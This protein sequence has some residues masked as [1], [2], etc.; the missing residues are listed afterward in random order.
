[1]DI[2]CQSPWNRKSCPHLLQSSLR[3]TLLIEQILQL[4]AYHPIHGIIVASP[5]AQFDGSRFNDPEYVRSYRSLML[6]D[7][8]HERHG[9]GARLEGEPRNIEIGFRGNADIQI[10]FD[11]ENI[12]VEQQLAVNVDGTATQLTTLSSRIDTVV[13]YVFGLEVSVNRASYGQLT[14]G[15]PLPIPE[16]KNV[17]NIQEDRGRFV[18]TS[19][20]LDAKLEGSLVVDGHPV[21]LMSQLQSCTSHAKPI[22][23]MYASKV[24]VQPG[25]SI[26]LAATFYLSSGVIS[27]KMDSVN[28]LYSTAA[29]EQWQLGN[30]EEGMI[31]KRNLEYILGNCTIPVGDGEVCLITDHVALP[32]GWNRDN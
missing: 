28:R 12:S 8:T 32:L 18:V 1:M 16:S 7:I 9:F 15:G 14:E 20:N 3:K 19:P 21:D 31:I 24:R 30:D 26:T 17:F 27:S 11:L 2:V 23:A 13:P 6:Q 25:R 29:R 4:S 22:S 5:H 10:N